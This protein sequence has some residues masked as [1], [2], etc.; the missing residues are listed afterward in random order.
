MDAQKVRPARPQPNESTGGV[1][2]G[3]TLRMLIDART[4]LAGFFSIQ[5]QFD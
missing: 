4:P 1:A 2:S 3:A 5:L